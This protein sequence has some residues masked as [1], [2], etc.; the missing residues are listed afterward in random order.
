[1]D[2]HALLVEVSAGNECL[3]DVL[4]DFSKGV[5]NGEVGGA[6]AKVVKVFNVFRW[7]VLKSLRCE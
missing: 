7:V 6:L 1:M 2:T 5:V 4:P 3:F